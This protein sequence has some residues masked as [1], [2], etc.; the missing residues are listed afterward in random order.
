MKLKHLVFTLLIC[1]ISFAGF[2]HTTTDLCQDSNHDIT[3]SVDNATIHG[4]ADLFVMDSQ[5]NFQKENISSDQ[6]NMPDLALPS[7][8][9]LEDYKL[10]ERRI[11]EPDQLYKQKTLKRSLI[12]TKYVKT[13]NRLA[14]D[15][16]NYNV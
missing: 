15:G 16:F 5:I 7:D 2:S 14:R 1:M 12:D 13:F 6:E 3:L 10:I 4:V 11:R 8:L 9:F